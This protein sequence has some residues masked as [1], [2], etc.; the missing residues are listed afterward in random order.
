VQAR[1]RLGVSLSAWAGPPGAGPPAA[2]RLGLR[3]Q[4][5]GPRAQA[6]VRPQA[7]AANLSYHP[8][9]DHD[10]GHGLARGPAGCLLLRLTPSP[11]QACMPSTSTGEECQCQCRAAC[12]TSSGLLAPWAAGL[13]EARLNTTPSAEATTNI[14]SP[15][16]LVLPARHRR[17]RR[18]RWG[19]AGT[20]GHGAEPGRSCSD[21][22]AK[23]FGT[24]PAADPT[25][26]AG[27][28]PRQKLSGTT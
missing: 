15:I 8:S 9:H 4:A 1:V 23:L 21:G 7:A 27:C 13:G 12:L 25:R 16:V 17:L 5:A 3:L 19:I 22:G 28:R 20:A 6:A 11:T 10:H 24:A 14:P 18:P 2:E 26:D